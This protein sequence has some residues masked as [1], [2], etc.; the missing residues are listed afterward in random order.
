MDTNARLLR[1]EIFSPIQRG[2]QDYK[3]GTLDHRDMNCYFN[4]SLAGYYFTQSTFCLAIQVRL[5]ALISTEKSTEGCTFYVEKA[6][7]LQHLR[8]KQ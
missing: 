6:P 8:S 1:A 5:L 2:I 7:I 3:S 4:I